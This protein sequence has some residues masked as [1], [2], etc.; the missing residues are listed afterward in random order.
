MYLRA[1]APAG[2]LPGRVAS[3]GSLCRR[4]GVDRSLNRA[5]LGAA[6]ITLRPLPE[7]AP[8]RLAVGP[9][10]GLG[11]RVL[12]DNF[13]A[14]RG[15]FSTRVQGYYGFGDAL[16]D[17]WLKRVYAYWLAFRSAQP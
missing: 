12:R 7:G 16:S 4:L 13:D 8:A 10:I 1:L 15:A 11:V 5:A 17:Y 6:T 9:R 3:P 2:P 14:V